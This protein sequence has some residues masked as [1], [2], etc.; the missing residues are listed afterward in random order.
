M[1]ERCTLVG[2]Y[3]QRLWCK[4]IASAK[5][6]ARP[7]YGFESTTSSCRSTCHGCRDVLETT[8][9]P[10]LRL[11]LLTQ[12]YRRDMEVGPLLLDRASDLLYGLLTAYLDT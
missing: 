1:L 5:L 9:A 10:A 2:H 8:S 12:R 11:F 4:L 6:A 3:F 7:N